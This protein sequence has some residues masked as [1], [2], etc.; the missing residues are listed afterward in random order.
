MYLSSKNKNVFSNI[1]E[2]YFTLVIK[3]H[4]NHEMILYPVQR[5]RAIRRQP[6]SCNSRITGVPVVG[7]IRSRTVI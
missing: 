1:A 4:V 2:H 6:T 3:T 5:E 7:E